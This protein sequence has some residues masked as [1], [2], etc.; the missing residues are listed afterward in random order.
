MAVHLSESGR[1]VTEAREAGRTT[2]NLSGQFRTGFP[3]EY[4]LL[5]VQICA[6][7]K[8]FPLQTRP[9]FPG[10]LKRLRSASDWH[11]VLEKLQRIFASVIF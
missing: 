3:S 10:M 4:F 1:E 5:T 7:F 6:E 2:V 11:A 8:T 9:A